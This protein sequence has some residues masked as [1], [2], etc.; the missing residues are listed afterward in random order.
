MYSF[1]QNK[2]FK[3]WSKI[4]GN[5]GGETSENFIV[6]KKSLN[7][8]CGTDEIMEIDFQSMYLKLGPCV[9]SKCM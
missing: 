8:L 1:L 4:L 2:T 6:K 3:T 9:D 7:W 5:V